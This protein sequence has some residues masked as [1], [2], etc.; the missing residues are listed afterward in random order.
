MK[1][2]TFKT[3]IILFIFNFSF[4]VNAQAPEKMSFQAVVRDDSNNLISNSQ[5]GMKVEMLQGS[6]TGTLVYEEIHTPMTNLNG[7]VSFEIGAGDI[8][9]GSLSEID[10]SQGP[11][12]IK[13]QTDPNGGSNY[14]IEGVSEL[15]SVPYALY[16]LNGNEGAAGTDGNGI[17]SVTE[18]NN[19]TF[20]LIFDDETTFTTSDLT[21]PQG[22][23]GETGSPG[24]QGPQGIAGPKG[25]KG[26]EGK[27]GPAGPQGEQGPRGEIGPQGPI[28]IH[29]EKG[30]KGEPGNDGLIGPQG[31]KGDKG[32]SGLQGSQGPEGLQGPAGPQ[33]EQGPK[34]EKGDQGTQ[35]I[36]GPAG[37]DLEYKSGSSSGTTTINVTF[38]S[39]MPDT[40]YTVNLTRVGSCAR[41]VH[42]SNKTTNGFE[43]NVEYTLALPLCTATIDW[44]AVPFK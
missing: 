33:G 26:D 13:T 27:Q 22:P 17:V 9:F 5:V 11:Y 14:S 29:G 7:L 18:N 6:D 31:P 36:P 38:S 35:G 8:I 20:T 43:I 23:K 41:G 32:D 16:A 19:G 12:F 3:L 2:F 39:P 15:L 25:E 44:L 34:G 24:E 37:S 40:N 21:G 30:A 28:G 4:D 10:W 42:I 1:N